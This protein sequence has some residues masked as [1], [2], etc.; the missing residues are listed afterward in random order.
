MASC[1]A[2]KKRPAVYER[3]VGSRAVSAAAM[4]APTRLEMLLMVRYSESMKPTGQ[5]LSFARPPTMAQRATRSEVPRLA[6]MIGHGVGTVCG[7]KTTDKLE[8]WP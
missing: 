3:P 2:G 4:D 7:V 6:A 8:R 5:L 1:K